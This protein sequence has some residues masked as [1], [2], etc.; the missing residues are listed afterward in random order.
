MYCNLSKPSWQNHEIDEKLVVLWRSVTF[1]TVPNIW[2]KSQYKNVPWIVNSGLSVNSIYM[3][4]KK[5]Y[6]MRMLRSEDQSR[7]IDEKL[8]V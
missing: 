7:E 1:F 4:G 8:A 3:F 6:T 5:A 2:F